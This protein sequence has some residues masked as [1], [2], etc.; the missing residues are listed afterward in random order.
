MGLVREAWGVEPTAT[1][2]GTRVG[3]VGVMQRVR[4]GATR[5]R[6]RRFFFGRDTVPWVRFRVGR[7]RPYGAPTARRHG[8]QWHPIGARSW[9]RWDPFDLFDMGNKS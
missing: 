1:G 5:T 2:T 8:C 6:L 9:S 3:V 7:G 4:D